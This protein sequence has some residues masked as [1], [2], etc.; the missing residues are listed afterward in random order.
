MI[1]FK[2]FG[3]FGFR[4]TDGQTVEQ[5]DIGGCRV[6]FATEKF[7]YLSHIRSIQLIRTKRY[8][9][10]IKS[11]GMKRITL[12]RSGYVIKNLF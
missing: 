3:G 9:L 2:L 5:T 1:D 10:D 8:N 7:N 6:A 4:Q 11:G 12:A